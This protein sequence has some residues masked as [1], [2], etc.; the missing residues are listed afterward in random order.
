MSFNLPSQSLHLNCLFLSQC[1]ALH[2]GFASGVT[3]SS[4]RCSWLSASRLAERRSHLR[5]VRLGRPL[6]TR[7]DLISVEE[8]IFTGL[9][10]L[11]DGAGQGL[12]VIKHRAE[13]ADVE[14]A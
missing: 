9:D 6:I 7:N 1:G 14:P 13:I 5:A 2:Y 4:A 11:P 12:L 10:R 8:V 3:Q